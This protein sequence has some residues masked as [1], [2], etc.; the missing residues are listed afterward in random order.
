M[1]IYKLFFFHVVFGNL[2]IDSHPQD[3]LDIPNSELKKYLDANK[4]KETLQAGLR[5]RIQHYF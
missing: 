5:I 3:T 4:T 2:L 1:L